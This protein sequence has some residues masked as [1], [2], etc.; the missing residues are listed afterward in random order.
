[1]MYLQEA[2]DDAVGLDDAVDLRVLGQ[3]G[4]QVVALGGELLG[5]WRDGHAAQ[6]VLGAVDR[7]V[8][9]VGTL[10]KQEREGVTL[11]YVIK[12]IIYIHICL[13]VFIYMYI[14]VYIYIYIYR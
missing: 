11:K 5:V 8:F 6:V 9:P 4:E 13:H 2:R 1:M 10:L 12:Q 14:Y 3:A 7:G